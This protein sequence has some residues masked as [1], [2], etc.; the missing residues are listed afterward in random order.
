MN[1]TLS[2]TTLG[3]LEPASRST[4]SPRCGRASR[5]AG[6][7]SRDT[8]TAPATVGRVSEDG[9]SRR[10]RRRCAAELDRYLVEHGSVAVDGVSLTVAGLAEDGFEVALIPETL[11]RTTLGELAEGTA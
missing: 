6:T 10:L 7:S 8:S 2:L 5:W 3:D 9:F 4:S 1:Q 11:D